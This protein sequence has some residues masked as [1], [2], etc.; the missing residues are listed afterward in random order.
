MWDYSVGNVEGIPVFH[1]KLLVG[2]KE[3]FHIAIH[4]MVK[5]DGGGCFHTHDGWG[6]RLV[7]WGGYVEEV[8]MDY[9]SLNPLAFSSKIVCWRP[10]SFGI[11]K[12]SFSHRVHSL[13]NGRVSYSL[14]I[15][16]PISAKV[17]LRGTG[18]TS[19]Q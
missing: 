10:G 16:G 17:Q 7:L 19:R 18:W 4:K 1:T 12:A 13:L 8:E 14:W 3:G 9:P 15:R 5:A 6:F 2:T 11:M